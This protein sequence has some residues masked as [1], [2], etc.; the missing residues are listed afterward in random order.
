MSD[1]FRAWARIEESSC[2]YSAFSCR[3]RVTNTRNPRPNNVSSSLGSQKNG[4][5]GFEADLLLHHSVRMVVLAHVSS[6]RGKNQAFEMIML[7]VCP[8]LCVSSFRI[9]NQLI[10][11]IFV[12]CI[13][14]RYLYVYV[15]NIYPQS[16]LIIFISFILSVHHMFRPLRAILRWITT[17]FIYLWKSSYHSTSVILIFYLF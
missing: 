8:H 17:S 10:Y 3:I 9:L 11:F 6:L 12:G 16:Q 4:P 7:F 14:T 5:P 13:L 15:P 2:M 1:I